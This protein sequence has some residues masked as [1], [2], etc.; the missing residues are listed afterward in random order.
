MTMK[1]LTEAK[2]LIISY[3]GRSKYSYFMILMWYSKIERL[4]SSLESN[5]SNLDK[6]IRNFKRVN[7]ESKKTVTSSTVS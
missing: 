1:E 3:T 4:Q 6:A 2:S 5:Q 7:T